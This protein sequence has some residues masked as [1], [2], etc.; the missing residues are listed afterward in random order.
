MLL[1]ALEM[2]DLDNN[3]AA[4]ADDADGPLL[5]KK[6]LK[7]LKLKEEKLAAKMAEKLEKKKKKQEDAKEALNVEATT[8]VTD[9]VN[10]VS[11]DIAWTDLHT[12]FSSVAQVD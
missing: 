5:T 12:E 3:N 9:E 7:A 4:D 11:I 6:E 1:K 10:G 8:A 2:E